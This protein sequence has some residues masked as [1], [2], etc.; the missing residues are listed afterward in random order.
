M[1]TGP[2]GTAAIAAA[3]RGTTSSPGTSVWSVMI[4]SR[5]PRGRRPVGGGVTLLPV[6]TE[7]AV[8]L[9]LDCQVLSL[10]VPDVDSERA[11]D[12]HPDRAARLGRLGLDRPG[13]A[14]SH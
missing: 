12:A 2:A 4:T 11:L 8:S 14:L 7:L 6:A 10:I 1:G 13:G 5:T 9:A 3:S